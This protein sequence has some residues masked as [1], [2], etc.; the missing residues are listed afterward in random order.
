MWVVHYLSEIRSCTK[1]KGQNELSEILWGDRTHIPKKASA[2]IYWLSASPWSL[3]LA[4]LFPSCLSSYLM[5]KQ[6]H[7]YSWSY[8]VW[9]LKRSTMINVDL[10]RPAPHWGALG[11]VGRSFLFVSSSV[12][13][14]PHFTA[15]LLWTTSLLAAAANAVVEFQLLCLLMAVLLKGLHGASGSQ[16]HAW[17]SGKPTWC[18]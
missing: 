4:G 6:S 13:E 5:N 1:Q 9:S 14:C 3:G 8:G 12:L 11:R 17:H 7:S 15:P 16:I 2:S 18:S 10:K